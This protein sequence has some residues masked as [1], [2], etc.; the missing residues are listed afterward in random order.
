MS[1]RKFV[2]IFYGW[3]YC[4]C[5][6]IF[7]DSLYYYVLF[8]AV[9]RLILTILWCQDV[10]SYHFVPDMIRFWRI[11]DNR[12]MFI[13]IYPQIKQWRFYKP[14]EIE[15]TN[16]HY[17]EIQSKDRRLFPNVN[18]SNCWISEEEEFA[19]LGGNNY[20]NQHFLG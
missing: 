10:K 17:L 1:P 6:Q 15:I 13:N 11:F 5:I 3:L 18:V 12:F 7:W 9:K 14:R 4:K 16:Q 8:S 2:Y 20:Q 19:I